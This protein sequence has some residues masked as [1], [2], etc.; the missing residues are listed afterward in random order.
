MKNSVSR[1]D[2]I[3][4]FRDNENGT[5]MRRDT[6]LFHNVIIIFCKQ[7]IVRVN[8]RHIKGPVNRGTSVAREL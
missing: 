1:G 3:P 4:V 8:K 2:I 6:E 7:D 5:A